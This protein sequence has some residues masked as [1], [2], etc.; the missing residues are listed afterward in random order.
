VDETG[1]LVGILT[2]DDVLPVVAQELNDLAA[3][4]QIQASGGCD[5]AR[6]AGA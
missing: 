6:G 3:I 2:L 4:A 5:P 1:A